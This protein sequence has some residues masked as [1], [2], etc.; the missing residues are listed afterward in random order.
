MGLVRMSQRIG[1]FVLGFLLSLLR[2]PE[3]LIGLGATASLLIF[4]Y[5]LLRRAYLAIRR[6][7]VPELEMGPFQ[8]NLLWSSGAFFVGIVAG[9]V[10]LIAIGVGY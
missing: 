9:L 4:A 1:A 5:L 6:K 2:A 7:R 3:A 8:V 10:A